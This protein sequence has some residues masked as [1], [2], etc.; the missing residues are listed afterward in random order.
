MEVACGLAKEVEG[1]RL[2]KIRSGSSGNPPD[3]KRADG[4]VAWRCNIQTNSPSARRLHYWC[5]QDGTIEFVNVVI[6]DDF[7]MP[8]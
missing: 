3:R 2:H 7:S 1:R 4:A 5:R 6:H 8:D